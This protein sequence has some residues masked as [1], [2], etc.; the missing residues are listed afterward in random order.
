MQFSAIP[1][2]EELKSQLTNS[3]KKGKVAHAQLFTGNPGTA[4]FPIAYAYATYLMC[5]NKSDS[6]SCGTCT[7]CTRMKKSIHPD[8]HWYFPKISASDGGKYEKVLGEA[9]PLWRT[10]ISDSPFGTF[11]DWT[12]KYGQENKNL[13]LSREDSRQILKNVSMRSVEGG[14]KII[15]VWGAEYMHSTAANA[16]LKVLEEP[17]EMTIFMLISFN[18]D[19]IL[20]TITSRTQL[21]SVTPNKPE[22]IENYLIEH[23]SAEQNQAQQLSKIA[24]GR[25]GLGL[26]LMQSDE[27]MAY[28]QFRDWMLGCWNRDLTFLV[29]ASEEFSKSGKAGQRGFLTFSLSLIRNSIL[30]L[31]GTQAPVINAE[32]DT[33]VTKYAQKLGAD[34][35]QNMYELLNTALLH[36]DRNANP[37]VTHLNLSLDIL[38][39]INS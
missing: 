8:V 14:Y 1:G 13:Q 9:L 15:L 38:R 25:I 31:A 22:E 27:E 34:K 3:F 10:F 37:R 16:M 20:K 23:A 7:N 26:R 29:K 21:V 36:L 5:E 17:P 19:S 28:E 35:L 33:F 39:K 32:E 4:A 11:E 30:K 18:Y 2:L 6:D 12:L 24:Q